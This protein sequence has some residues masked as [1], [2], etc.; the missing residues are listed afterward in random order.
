MT[1]DSGTGPTIDLTEARAVL[2]ARLAKIRSEEA[3]LQAVEAGR[4]RA[5][6][7]QRDARTKLDDAEAALTNAVRD[8]PQRRA[9]QFINQT[10]EDDPVGIAR[11]AVDTARDELNKLVEVEAALSEEIARVQDG[12]RTQHMKTWDAMAAVVPGQR[13]YRGIQEIEIHQRGV[14]GGRQCPA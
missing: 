7:V 4:D 6:Q 1:T 2:R 11:A 8:E 14:E 13:P 10:E 12:L 3:R 5:R 9:Y